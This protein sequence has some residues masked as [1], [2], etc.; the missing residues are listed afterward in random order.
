MT[1]PTD[2]TARYAIR[3]E[4]EDGDWI[5]YY[6]DATGRHRIVRDVKHAK[7]WTLD[8]GREWL[9]TFYSSA[10]PDCCWKLVPLPP[11]DVARAWIPDHLL[12]NAPCP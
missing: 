7:I 5:G 4:P 10:T 8:A 3:W 11:Y 6:D 2:P 1:T 12:E 9:G